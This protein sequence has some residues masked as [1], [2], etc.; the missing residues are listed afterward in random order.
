MNEFSFF[1]PYGLCAYSCMCL[2]SLNESIDRNGQQD[3]GLILPD[4]F[5]D[6]S[7]VFPLCQHG[8]QKK[9]FFHLAQKNFEI[10]L[11]LEK[12]GVQVLIKLLPGVSGQKSSESNRRVRLPSKGAVSVQMYFEK[13]YD[14]LRWE[15]IRRTLN[16]IGFSQQMIK[17][18]KKNPIF[19]LPKELKKKEKEE[20]GQISYCVLTLGKREDQEKNKKFFLRYRN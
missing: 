17:M 14:R 1:P 3:L 20:A 4:R 13:S 12:G 11:L 19:L 18:K 2:S 15:F 5:T 6:Q 9:D 10:T 8:S 7:V 16:S